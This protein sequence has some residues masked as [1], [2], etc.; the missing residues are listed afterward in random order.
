MEKHL[1][2]RPMMYRA[3]SNALQ[4]AA[5]QCI[6]LQQTALHCDTRISHIENILPTI[7]KETHDVLKTRQRTGSTLQHAALHCNTCIS[8]VE[9]HMQMRPML[10]QRHSN[11]LAVHCNTLHYTATRCI[12]LHYTATLVSL[13]MPWTQNR[14]SQCV[15]VF[16]CVLHYVAVC[17]TVQQRVAVCCNVT[18]VTFWMPWTQ[19]GV[20][21]CVAVCC[22]VLHC[23]TVC[24]NVTHVTLWTPW[25]Q[26]SVLQC[27]AV[28]CSVLQCVAT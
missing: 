17:C 20:L 10:Y 26:S 6:T 4:Y 24:C 12:T 25:I 3:H 11:A 22:T 5:T 27:V 13:R 15:V 8:H 19:S 14:S 2:T 1:Q 28:C 7:C 23:V 18:H 9:K 16:C 21:Q